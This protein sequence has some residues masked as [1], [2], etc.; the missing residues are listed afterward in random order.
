MSVEFNSIYYITDSPTFISSNQYIILDVTPTDGTSMMVLDIILLIIILIIQTNLH[1]TI[2]LG[3][4]CGQKLNDTIFHY[5][6]RTI[7]DANYSEISKT[8][9]NPTKILQMFDMFYE[10]ESINCLLF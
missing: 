1:F 2:P 4:Q 6:L 3:I 8:E 10:N 9:Y 7:Q 5:H